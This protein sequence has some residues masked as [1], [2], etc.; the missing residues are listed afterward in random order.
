VA[1][2]RRAA[3]LGAGT[4]NDAVCGRR[5]RCREQKLAASNCLGRWAKSDWAMMPPAKRRTGACVHNE[6]ECL[7]K[8]NFVVDVVERISF[9][10]FFP[11]TLLD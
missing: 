7:I 5:Y 4:G 9:V 6:M 11:K 1:N 2:S 3:S 8:Q 10:I